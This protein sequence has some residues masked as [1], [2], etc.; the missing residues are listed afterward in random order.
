MENKNQP[1][2]ALTREMCE[3]PNEI[4]NYPYGLTK[5]EYMATQGMV[6]LL[7]HPGTAKWD[8]IKLAECAVRHANS[9]LKELD[10]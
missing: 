4:E 7:S 2:F 10:K 1:A 3:A 6:G 8:D 5:R 9:L